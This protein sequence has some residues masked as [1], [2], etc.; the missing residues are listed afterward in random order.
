MRRWILRLIGA[1]ESGTWYC[2][3]HSGIGN[4][5]DHGCDFSYQ[6]TEAAESECEKR[7]LFYV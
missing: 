3:V 6:D 1:K 2:P 5:D 7:E 4:E